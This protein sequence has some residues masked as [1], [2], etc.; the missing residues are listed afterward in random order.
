MKVALCIPIAD[1]PEM[2][3]LADLVDM[4]IHTFSV[5]P[6]IRLKRCIISSSDLCMSRHHLVKEALAWGAD[7]LLWM[8]D[9]HAFP[10]DALVR[11]LDRN[12]DIVGCNYRR[13]SPPYGFTVGIGN[14]CIETTKERAEAFPVELVDDI[15]LGLALV[16]AAAIRKLDPP[17]PMFSFV[18]RGDGDFSSEHAFFFSRLRAAGV[19]VHVDHELSL[20]VGHVVTQVLWA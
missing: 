9:D 13:R 10:P 15:P 19:P 11:L 1:R 2:K 17:F 6:D 3:F 8:D 14:V 4:V 7:W 18:P 12:L 5:R 16:S 20:K